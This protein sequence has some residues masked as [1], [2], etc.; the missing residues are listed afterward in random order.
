MPYQSDIW[1]WTLGFHTEEKCPC[2]KVFH[3]LLRVFS[4]L[5]KVL[6]IRNVLNK[7]YL[8]IYSTHFFLLRKSCSGLTFFATSSASE[9]PKANENKAFTNPILIEFYIFDINKQLTWPQNV[10][11][12]LNWVENQRNS[13]L[14]QLFSLTIPFYIF[15]F[16]IPLKPSSGNFSN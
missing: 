15:G 4:I 11:K 7:K 2:P 16:M 13:P 5:S 14:S 1:T 3:E 10:N 6:C 8:A 12:Q 9:V